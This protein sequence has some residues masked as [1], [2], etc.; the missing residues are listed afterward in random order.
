M[1]LQVNLDVDVQQIKQTVHSPL[2]TTVY[3]NY[4]RRK[5]QSWIFTNS[6]L[7]SKMMYA[8]YNPIAINYSGAFF[9]L[10]DVQNAKIEK[11]VGINNCFTFHQSN[12]LR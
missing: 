11:G 8:D 6:S 9:E 12:K 10:R 3:K 5:F 2:R 4:V 1:N 7:H